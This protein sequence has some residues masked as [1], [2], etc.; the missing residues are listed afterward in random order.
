MDWGVSSVLDGNL[1]PSSYEDSTDN[2]NND[3]IFPG[4][5]LGSAPRPDL[6]AL[7][8]TAA[9]GEVPILC[10]MSSRHRSRVAF[11]QELSMLKLSNLIFLHCTMIDPSVAYSRGAPQS[12]NPPRRV[13]LLGHLSCHK[14]Q[15]RSTL[16][17]WVDHVIAT[18]TREAVCPALR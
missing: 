13:L 15:K 4:Q 9:V 5:P 1:S 17:L 2:S 10:V 3:S 11:F 12:L 18:C 16:F 7:A 6:L 14:I 8:Q